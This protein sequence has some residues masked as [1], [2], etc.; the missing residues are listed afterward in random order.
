MNRRDFINSAVLSSLALTL[1]ARGLL[2]VTPEKSEDLFT[3][4][5]REFLKALYE[6]AQKNNW[7]DMPFGDLVGMVGYEFLGTQYEAGTLEGKTEICRVLLDRLDCVTFFET[8]LAIATQ[9]MKQKYSVNDLILRV[10]F[11][12]YRG[13]LED[14]YITRLHYTADWIYDNIQKGIIYDVTE[15]LGGEKY[16]PNVSFMSKNTNY[17]PP[18]KENPELVEEIEKIELDI[19]SRDYYYVPKDKVEMIEPMLLTGD[20]IAITTPIEGLDYGHVGMIY[21]IEDDTSRFLHASSEQMKVVLDDTISKYL[22]RN[23]RQTG[24]TIL[25]PTYSC[26]LDVEE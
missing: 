13:G 11:T 9:I 1:G 21:K 7:R 20:I 14:G 10:G 4:E 16:A 18:L 12:R 23:K 6:K 17:Y 15:E 19:N 26:P 5:T 8:S 22:S 3:Y 2:S 25:R 24:I